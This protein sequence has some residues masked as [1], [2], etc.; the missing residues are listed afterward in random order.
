M[1]LVR[2]FARVVLTGLVIGLAACGGDDDDDGAAT[3]PPTTAPATEPAN[4]EETAE[5]AAPGGNG[6]TPPG[7]ELAVGEKAQVALDPLNDGAGEY[8]LN[9]TVTEIHK[10]TIAD[11]STS[12]LDE[13]QQLSAPYY[14]Y[15]LIE[16]T[17]DTIPADEDP[18]GQFKAVD[19]RGQEHS[20]FLGDLSTCPH[21]ESLA[22]KGW[23]FEA[24]VTYLV[25]G[26]VPIE[27]VRWDRG[28]QEY[29]SDPVVWKV[30]RVSGR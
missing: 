5:E 8:T 28:P 14:V 27:E 11:I 30:T 4:T 23:G 1:K 19:A 10:G 6:L 22:K 16:N 13:D 24:C 2:G 21:D 3:P 9:V 7:T 20:V 12:E 25:P 26:G 29:S 15:L 18:V 17:G